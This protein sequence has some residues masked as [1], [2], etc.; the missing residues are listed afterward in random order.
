MFEY[1]LI[2]SLFFHY[3][4]S[5]ITGLIIVSFRT[6]SLIPNRWS[7]VNPRSKIQPPSTVYACSR[8]CIVQ[9]VL[10]PQPCLHQLGSFHS[11][12]RAL[13]FRDPNLGKRSESVLRRCRVLSCLRFPS[14]FLFR[15]LVHWSYL[16]PS[17]RCYEG[18]F[19]FGC[20]AGSKPVAGSVSHQ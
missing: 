10:R 19:L 8:G 18:L 11:T 7:L 6:P 17:L 5:Y 14:L 16:R 12:S 3:L 4:N 1:Q 15:L 13:F 9:S 20:A 2:D